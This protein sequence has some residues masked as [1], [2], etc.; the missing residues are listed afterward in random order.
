NVHAILEQGPTPAES[1]HDGPAS[2]QQAVLVPLAAKNADR[3]QA[4]ARELLAFLASP[5]GESVALADLAYTF[6]VGRKPLPARAVFLVR[7]RDELMR[8]LEAFS[9]TTPPLAGCVC[10]DV[11]GESCG[12]TLLLFENADAQEAMIRA[13]LREKNLSQLARVWV[14]GSYIDWALLHENDTP[15]S[16]PRRI[17]LPTYPFAKERYGWPEHRA[18]THV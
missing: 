1:R 2:V 5:E 16:Q 15:V 8:Q 11:A 18:V 10:G 3:L 14:Q 12:A 4:Y 9:A 17:S 13:W 6:Q 7:T